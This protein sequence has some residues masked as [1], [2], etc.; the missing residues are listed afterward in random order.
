MKYLLTGAIYVFP[1]M[2]YVTHSLPLNESIRICV[3]SVEVTR[4]L[5]YEF[6][7][8]FI[9]YLGHGELLICVYECEMTFVCFHARDQLCHNMDMTR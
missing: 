6:D 9:C 8:I 5:C 3:I 2:G 7:P 1:S 4:Y